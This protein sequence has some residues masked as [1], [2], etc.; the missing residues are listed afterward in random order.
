MSARSCISQDALQFQDLDA[1]LAIL[2]WP[3]N[4]GE[5]VFTG[6]FCIF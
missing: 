6:D 1:I 4:F 5:F 2:D 3:L